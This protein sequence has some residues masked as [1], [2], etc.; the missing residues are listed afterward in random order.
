MSKST[1]VCL[2]P[3]LLDQMAPEDPKAVASR[4][5]IKRINSVMFQGAIMRSAISRCGLGAPKR[6]LDLGGGDGTFTLNVARRMSPQWQGVELVIVDRVDVVESLT[7][8]EFEKIGW[9]LNIVV[10]DVFSFLER[11]EKQQFDLILS[12]LFIHHFPADRLAKLLAMISSLTT[13]FVACEPRRSP[14]TVMGSAML[15]AIGCTP[16]TV[17]DSVTGARAGFAK[18][19]LSDRWPNVSSWELSEYDTGLF[20]HC[21]VARK[22]EKL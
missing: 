6:V 16:V 2:G 10:S 8:R 7:K 21:F 5:D 18:K 15:W 22:R 9:D 12:N 20:S 13:G 14:L 19:E 11:A 3:D 1:R 17:R 4:S